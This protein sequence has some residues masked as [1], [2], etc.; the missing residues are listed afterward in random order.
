M[1]FF[2]EMLPHLLLPPG[3]RSLHTWYK[4]GFLKSSKTVQNL[5][6]HV[7]ANPQYKATNVLDVNQK[8]VR[9]P[10]T[11]Q[12]V[13]LCLFHLHTSLDP[14]TIC[15]QFLIFYLSI[16]RRIK[17]ACLVTWHWNIC[18]RRPRVK[19]SQELWNAR[20]VAASSVKTA[21]CLYMRLFSIVPDVSSPAENVNKVEF[22]LIRIIK[23]NITQKDH[24]YLALD[25]RLDWK[26]CE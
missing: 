7:T 13:V 4:W 12:Y 9:S 3:Q 22:I 21:T 23:L 24:H 19:Q 20:N 15:S 10:P 25:A 5:S 16:K 2:W 14:T 11:V 18:Q 1:I 6:V 17:S 8:Y 26:R